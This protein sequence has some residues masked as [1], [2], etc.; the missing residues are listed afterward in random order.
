MPERRYE[1]LLLLH[2]DLGEAG[3]HEQIVRIQTLI[4]EKGATISATHEW[5]QRDLAYPVREQRRAIFALFELRAGTGTLT[6]IERNLKLMEP[7]LRFLS[8][9]QDEDAP[10]AMELRS[11]EPRGFGGDGSR[12]R[13]RGG[14]E[15]RPSRGFRSDGDGDAESGDD[16]S[17]DKLTTEEGV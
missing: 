9:G 15:G 14:W 12:G 3:A 17:D 10:A 16:D 8:V 13:D 2:P 5:G 11:M 1:T 6:E 4:E 7:V